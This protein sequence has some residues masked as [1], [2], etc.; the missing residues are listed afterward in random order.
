MDAALSSDKLYHSHKYIYSSA[1]NCGQDMQL[2]ELCGAECLKNDPETV[3]KDRPFQIS[4]CLH[5]LHVPILNTSWQHAGRKHLLWSR[6]PD[7]KHAG[8]Q[9]A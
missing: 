5:V 9:E 6:L 8:L 4:M 1:P 7:E 2:C 3:T